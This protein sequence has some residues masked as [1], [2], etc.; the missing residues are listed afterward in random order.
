MK[1]DEKAKSLLINALYFCGNKTF[2]FELALYF[3]S[4]ILEQKLKA[5]DR[6]YWSVVQDEIYQTNK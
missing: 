2:A 4:L 3:C 5:D 1:P 6:A